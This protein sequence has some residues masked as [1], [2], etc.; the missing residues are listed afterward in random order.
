MD[1]KG[2]SDGLVAQRQSWL[3]KLNTTRDG[4]KCECDMAFNVI[5]IIYWTLI[6]D[7]LWAGDEYNNNDYK[8]IGGNWAHLE[9]RLT[10]WH[11]VRTL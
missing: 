3:E 10:P 2:R 5:L 8:L 7:F 11:V 9:S 6:I 1:R 4:E